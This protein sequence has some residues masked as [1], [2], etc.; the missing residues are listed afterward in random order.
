MTS[1]E[2]IH[3]MKEDK[4]EEIKKTLE[5]AKKELENLKEDNPS[6]NY[7]QY[8]N[9]INQLSYLIED[10]LPKSFVRKLIFK[11]VFCL[12]FLFIATMILVA[13]IFGFSHSL[14]NPLPPLH[15]LYI[16]PLLSLILV[17]L[18]RILILLM[19]YSRGNPFWLILVFSFIIIFT[20]A[21]VDSYW[22][23][24]CESLDSSLLLSSVLWLSFMGL[25]I[26][27][28]KKFFL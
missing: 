23:H 9:M 2:V 1:S 28:Q 18:M 20:F 16:I 26:W 7:D 21:M 12:L 22:L 15:F 14:F 8:E 25:D 5:H 27:I 6:G 13:A 19:N 11:F 4:K 24:L 3:N 17:I 10:R